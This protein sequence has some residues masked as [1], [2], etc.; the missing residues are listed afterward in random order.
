MFNTMLALRQ[1]LPIH[2]GIQRT[3]RWSH[4]NEAAAI[5]YMSARRRGERRSTQQHDHSELDVR[6]EMYRGCV[7]TGL[8]FSQR[9]E[10]SAEGGFRYIQVEYMY[11][12][13]ICRYEQA[14]TDVWM[15][16]L[17]TRTRRYLAQEFFQ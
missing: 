10:A 15:A 5:E 4:P 7:S 17:S 12:Y 6:F 1:E 14:H 16:E 11:S 9:L 2:I 8:Q 3:R 13:M